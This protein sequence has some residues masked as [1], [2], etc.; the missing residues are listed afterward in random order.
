M[1]KFE[2][3]TA[4]LQELFELDKADLDFGIHRIIKQKHGQIKRY[5]ESTLPQKVK[6]VLSDLSR[7]QNSERL[8]ELRARIQEE[9]GRRAFDDNGTLAD[10]A[11]Q[12]DEMGRQY[13]ALLEASG[14]SRDLERIEAEVYSHLYDFF[15]RYYEDGDFISLRRSSNKS[16]YAIGYNG[17]EVLLHWANKDQYYIKSTEDMKDYTFTLEQGG[18]AYRV[19]FKLTRMDAVQNNNQAKRLFVIDDETDIQESDSVL[20]I[21]FH[22]KEFTGRTPN[23]RQLVA[24]LEIVLNAKMSPVWKERLAADDPTYTGDDGRTVLQKH[25]QNYTRKNTSDYFIHKDLG[26]FLNTELDFYIKN[27][28]MYL[29]DVD[30]RPANYLEAEIRKIKAIRLIAKDLIAFL[31]QFEDFQKKLWLKKKFVYDT[32]YCITL[33]RVPETLYADIAANDAQRAEWVRLF[34]IDQIQAANGDLLEGGSPAYSEPLTVE[35]LKANPFLVLDTA[36]FDADFKYRLLATIEDIDAQL[37]G[38]LIHSENFQALNLLQERYKQQVKCIY[39]D[40]PFNLGETADYLYKVDYKDSTWMTLLE[41]RSRLSRHLLRKSGSKMIRCNHDGNM[42]VRMLMNSLFGSQNYR[43]EIIV[44]RAEES[45]GDLNKQFAGVKSITVN[46]DNLYWYSN[47]QDTRFGRFLKPTGEKQ[48]Q[49]HWHS[50]WKAENRPNLRYD[51]LGIDLNNHYGQWM[52]KRERAYRAVQNY[53]EYENNRKKTGIDLDSYWEQN[54]EDYYNKHSVNL[55]F[56]KRDGDGYSS[57]K[58]WIPPRAQVMADNNWLD[59]K[60]YANKWGFK[61]ENSEGLL[62]RIIETLSDE[63]DFVLDYFAG[64]GTTACVSHKLRRKWI[65]VEMGDHFD[66][67]LH[68]RIRHVL[69]GDQSG[70]SKDV[71]WY[72]GGFFKYMRLESYEDTLNNLEVEDRQ[73]DL[74]GLP[75]AVQEQYLLG[76]MLDLETRGSL[77]GL[78]RFENP[79]DTTLKIYNRQTG[80]AEPKPIDLP[81]T[82]NYLLG[83]R[84]REVKRRDG[85][86]TVEGENPAGETVLIIWRNVT[87]QDNAALERF[88]VETLRINTADTEYHAIYIN[89]DTTLNDPHKKILLTEEAFNALMFDQRGLL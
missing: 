32:Q 70:V 6:S 57:I 62:K 22:F 36:F 9:F 68:Q 48:S 17:E 45:K 51:I 55:E 11:A 60:G 28:V 40:P 78:G 65:T 49:S 88:V 56:I 54:A 83:L 38:L 41:N 25:L 33:D 43:N 64:S 79:F 16:K 34:A 26:G 1:S 84:V 14:E 30:D 58:Y 59:I 27:E 13:L 15:S 47:H 53:I 86:L 10:P 23:N 81:E 75:D 24:E 3:L 18:R 82:F 12:Q 37:D 21:P 66:F 4:K 61:T 2:E 5:L 19:H 63:R 89:G 77:L 31:A 44:R 74:L 67:I 76:Y 80:K 69:F 52:W 50:F 73:Q 29:D 42:L 39:I 46:Y 87:E 71:E 7:A 8:E 20:V 72:G 85:F 35:F